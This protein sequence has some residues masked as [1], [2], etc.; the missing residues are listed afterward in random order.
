MGYTK[1]ARARNAQKKKEEAK[2]VPVSAP[3]ADKVV[4]S[5]ITKK[6]IPLNTMVEVRNGFN[7]KLVYE[8]KKN[9]GY[10]VIFDSFGD[11]EYF[12]LQE[13][14]AAVN[15]YKKFFINNWFI[16][17]DVEILEFLNVS[18]YYKNAINID[19]FDE[20]F[21]KSEGEMKKI[22]DRMSDGQKSTFI[23]RVIHLIED[24]TIDS[25]KTIDALEN[26]LQI[27]LIEK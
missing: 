4:K 1:E 27:D 8:S 22:I 7:G 13:L 16:I 12:E 26:I 14:I 9:I 25:R 6:E 18:K 21:S 11:T 15:S 17:D 10:T 23:N 24:G 20:V 5:R 2:V 19:D 3:V